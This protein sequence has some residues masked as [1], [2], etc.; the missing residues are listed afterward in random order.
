MSTLFVVPG[1]VGEPTGGNIYDRRLVGA[2]RADGVEIDLVPV[3][4]RWPF[5]DAAARTELAATLAAARPGDTLLLDGMVAGAVPDEVAAAAAGRRVVLLEHLPLADETGVS[6]A[7]GERL[8][9][10]ERATLALADAVVATSAWTADRVAVGYDVPPE[11][12]HVVEPGTDP[13]PPAVPSAEGGRLLCV[14]AVTPRKGQH[15]LAAALAGLGERGAPDGWSCRC[16]GPLNRAPAYVEQVRRAAGSLGEGFALLGVRSDAELL[17]DYA[18]TDLLVLP[19]MVETYGMVLAE[20]LVR[21]IPVLSTTGSAVEHTVA[22][23]GLLVP[24]GDVDA[25]ADALARWLGEPGV[26]EQLRGRAAERG[27][28]LPTWADAARGMA[29]VLAWR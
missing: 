11:R 18:A 23:A 22:G 24:P 13:A 15:V 9:A 21:G 26:R 12:L 25:L 16:V 2:L 6:P 29:P 8:R 17:A 28:Q 7:E 27:R 14:A 19:T 1:D 3:A 5:P 20:A 10:A 4:G